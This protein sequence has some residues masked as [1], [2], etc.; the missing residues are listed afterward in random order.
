MKS[1]DI[2]SEPVVKLVKT[3]ATSAVSNLSL[4][5]LLKFASTSVC[6]R[7]LPLPDLVTIVA[8]LSIQRDVDFASVYAQNI[9]NCDRFAGGQ[10]RV[11]NQIAARCRR[12]H[13]NMRDSSP[14][15][16]RTGWVFDGARIGGQVAADGPSCCLARVAIA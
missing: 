13:A 10:R 7:A 11:N 16:G 14:G 4:F 15:V 8:I 2:A 9:A 12:K 6:V 3:A 1:V 5:K